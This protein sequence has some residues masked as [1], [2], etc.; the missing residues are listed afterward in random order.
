[1]QGVDRLD[2]LMKYYSFLRKTRRWTKKIIFYFLQIGLQNAYALYR[3]YTTDRPELTHLKFHTKAIEAL[4]YFDPEEWPVVGPLIPHA[5]NLPG[6]AAAGAAAAAAAAAAGA[7]AGAA[8]AA[9]VPPP[10]PG[11][12]RSSSPDDPD[13]PP[14][15]T[16][17][18]SPSA[19]P[20]Q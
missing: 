8:A 6:A 10:V 2:Q 9:A 13:S 14:P 1:M 19:T 11:T 16:P 3:K 15:R 18:G 17:P 12:P 20:R 5:P 7:A 4:V